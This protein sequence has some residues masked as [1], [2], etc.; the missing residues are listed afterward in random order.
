MSPVT[1]RGKTNK[2]YQFNCDTHIVSATQILGSS[3]RILLKHLPKDPRHIHNQTSSWIGKDQLSLSWW[4][5]SRPGMLP[6]VQCPL[7]PIKS[8]TSSLLTSWNQTNGGAFWIGS[9][10]KSALLELERELT[11]S[12]T[13]TTLLEDKMPALMEQT[14]MIKEENALLKKLPNS[15]KEPQPQQQRYYK[16]MIPLT[17]LTLVLLG[18]HSASWTRS[19]AILL[20][21]RQPLHR[22][23]LKFISAPVPPPKLPK[24]LFSAEFSP[25]KVLLFQR[26]PQ[27]D[28][29]WVPKEC[30]PNW[31][32]APPRPPAWS[33]S[34]KIYTTSDHFCSK[35]E[36]PLEHLNPF[37]T[38]SATR[39]TSWPAPKVRP[40]MKVTVWI[41][42]MNQHQ[43]SH[44]RS[45]YETSCRTSWLQRNKLNA[46]SKRTYYFF[47]ANWI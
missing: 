17:P 44:L 9:K 41:H 30:F 40:H 19:H 21:S 8:T 16:R 23:W 34:L 6:T 24:Y 7:L 15:P 35:A 37:P 18:R 22:A 42:W 33:S 10:R 38:R 32:P 28:H 46:I 2:T 11:V 27:K 45:V 13:T 26:L 1:K 20:L 12:K 14:S 5:A 3:G 31:F 43:P 36:D 47:T 29:R 39:L 4:N 25:Y